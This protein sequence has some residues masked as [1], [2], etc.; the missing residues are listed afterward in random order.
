MQSSISSFFSAKGKKGVPKS[1]TPQPLEVIELDASDEETSVLRSSHNNS[2][3]T[4]SIMM[5]NLSSSSAER[6]AQIK[7]AISLA[8]DGVRSSSSSSKQQLL[9]RS[10]CSSNASDNKK[11]NT[12]A[13]KKRGSS[14]SSSSSSSGSADYTPLEKQVV[15]LKKEHPDALLMVECGYRI[16]FFGDDATNAAKVLSIYAH[17]DHSFQVA[18]V[19]THRFLVHA[20]RLINAG[21][22]VGLVRQTETAAIHK[23]SSKSSKTFVRSCVGL[24]TPGTDIDDDDPAFV[25][26]LNQSKNNGGDAADGSDTEADNQLQTDS[27]ALSSSGGGR[28]NSDGRLIAVVFDDSES[29][30]TAVVSIDIRASIVHHRNLNGPDRT[31]ARELADYVDILQPCEVLTHATI[32]LAQWSELLQRCKGVTVI[33]MGANLT[34]HEATLPTLPNAS[35]SRLSRVPG[36]GTRIVAKDSSSTTVLEC[37]SE[38]EK[39]ALHLLQHYLKGLLM[40]LK[41]EDIDF[42]SDNV[43]DFDPTPEEELGGNDSSKSIMMTKNLP[44]FRLDPVTARDLEIFEVEGATSTT[45]MQSLF[46]ELNHCRT[47]F[48]KRTLRDWLSAPLTI[49]QDIQNRQGA[50]TYFLE[51]MQEE[52]SGKSKK[53]S[54]EGSFRLQFIACLERVMSNSSSHVERWLYALQRGRLSPSSLASLLQWSCKLGELGELMSTPSPTDEVIPSIVIAYVDSKSLKEVASEAAS[55]LSR[56]SSGSGDGWKSAT[57]GTIMSTLGSDI[58]KPFL[59]LTRKIQELRKYEKEMQDN[60]EEVCKILRKPALKFRSLATGGGSSIEHLIEVDAK[61][62]ASNKELVPSD[63]IPMNSTKTVLRFHSPIVLNTQAKLFLARDEVASAAREAWKEFL[64]MQV[65]PVIYSR[66]KCVIDS[67]GAIDCLLSLARLAAR[68]GYVCPQYTSDAMN[69]TVLLAKARHPMA[70]RLFELEGQTQFQPND[71]TIRCNSRERCCL[72]VTGPNMGGKSTYVRM[73]SVLC[74]M[75]QVGSYVPAESAVFP[76]FD[77]IFT[78]M[79][80]GDDLAAGRST[81]ATE[82]YRTNS[83]IRR[84][85]RRS[86]VVLDELGRGTSTNDGVCIAMATLQYFI[87]NIGCAM[88]FVTHYAQVS[89][90]VARLQDKG[91]HDEGDSQLV[92]KAINVHMGYLETSDTSSK[93]QEVLF[94]YQVVEGPSKGSY[95]LNIGR[96]A[97]LSEDLLLKAEERAQWMRQN[98]LTTATRGDVKPQN[99]NTE[100]NKRTLGDMKDTDLSNFEQDGKSDDADMHEDGPKQNEEDIEREEE[101]CRKLQKLIA[102]ST[103]R[104]EQ[105]ASKREVKQDWRNMVLGGDISDATKALGRHPNLVGKVVHGEKRGRTIGYPTAN[106]GIDEDREDNIVPADGVYAGWIDVKGL[107]LQAAISIGTNP[108][109]EGLRGRQVEAFALKQDTWL[110]LYDEPATI[111]FKERLRETIKFTG[112]DWLDQLLAQMKLDCEKAWELT[113]E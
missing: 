46:R 12:K 50:V 67:I 36:I 24:Y 11:G 77:N 82:L 57:D 70:E 38:P 113:Q 74:L 58:L 49:A 40:D 65:A 97:G 34:N 7:S 88:F 53:R 15:A 81:F 20:R 64:L 112:A 89:D 4:M 60:L 18:S 5:D 72:V 100:S 54:G 99:L 52:G 75:G 105:L 47:S 96:L 56:I 69:D 63:W 68:P 84:A 108:T 66:M 30:T 51:A 78:R 71:T 21:Y 37:L 2:S 45:P 103:R 93:N 101:E 55:L 27:S 14:S 59:D 92:G 3:A 29:N 80:A 8:F 16:R 87:K 102:D 23:V 10:S 9:T 25:D 48:G 62:V 6:S 17:K 13:S 85:T 44:C 35:I 43:L 111:I 86:L 22:Q 98:V 61:D 110:D 31:R 19:P 76:V 42:R 26:L 94:L 41:F 90:M 107:R 104:L 33:E 109:F 91:A 73:V 83:I 106:L 79:G 28:D 39:S 32:S 95:G 1:A